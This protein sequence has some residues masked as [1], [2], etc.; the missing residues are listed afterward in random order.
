MPLGRQYIV[1]LYARTPRSSMT[2]PFVPLPV[3]M[4]LGR[5]R[6]DYVRARLVLPETDPSM[7]LAS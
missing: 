4:P 3:T 7:F 6:G 2:R 5:H 1:L